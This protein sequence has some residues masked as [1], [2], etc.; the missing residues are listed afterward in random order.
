V[1]QWVPE[2][3]PPPSEITRIWNLAGKDAEFDVIVAQRFPLAVLA[4]LNERFFASSGVERR[5]RRF[6]VSE[7]AQEHGRNCV[8][9]IQDKVKTQIMDGRWRPTALTYPRALVCHM[10]L[11]VCASRSSSAVRRC[12]HQSPSQLPAELFEE[13]AKRRVSLGLI[14]AKW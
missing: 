6:S 4:E 2:G 3:D 11:I 5:Y 10:K 1:S 12:K 9:A 8:R 13:Q 7:V 14:V